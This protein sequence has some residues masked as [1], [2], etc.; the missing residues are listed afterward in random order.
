MVSAVLV[1]L[2]GVLIT[3]IHSLPAVILGLALVC[4]GVFISQSTASSHLQDAAPE[5]GRVS[6]AG[7]YLSFYYLG[8]TAAGV[9]PSFFW[10]LGK[11]PACVAFI[12]TLQ[13]ITMTI[14]LLG[15]RTD[16]HLA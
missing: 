10:N 12:V 4:T 8:G 2:V 11:W 3:L 14:A 15:W 16:P 1:S 5:G 7:L 6:A 9:V 13:L